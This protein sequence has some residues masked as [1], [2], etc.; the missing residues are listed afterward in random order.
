M[1]PDMAFPLSLNVAGLAAHARLNGAEDKRRS[2]LTASYQTLGGKR[3]NIPNLAI[4]P[5]LFYIGFV[6]ITEQIDTT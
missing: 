3:K 6:T 2:Y 5:L 4:E 1:G